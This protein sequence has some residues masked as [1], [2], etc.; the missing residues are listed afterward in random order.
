MRPKL[1]EDLKVALAQPQGMVVVSTPPGG[2]L[3]TLFAATISEMDRFV[4][5]FVGIESAAV[6]ELNVENVPMTY[7]DPAA[8][9]TPTAVLP[10][11]IREHPD[12]YVVPDMVDA[13]SATMLCE[14]VEQE[15]R[16]VVTSI[17]AK[18]AAESLLRV[19]MLKVPPAKFA[20]S[21]T[22]ALNQRLIRKL[23]PKCKE[24]YAPTAQVLEQLGIPAGRVEAFY[25]PPQQ[26]EEVCTDC[27][28]I[29]YLGRDWH[30]RAADRRRQ[31]ARSTYHESAIGGRPA[32]GAAGRA[33]ARCRKRGSCSWPRGSRRCKN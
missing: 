22:V 3:S 27:Q 15:N 33:C 18:E 1:I 21:V 5:G 32:S 8:G 29:G 24:G 10:K 23:C 9:Q 26:P 7:F 14:Q 20:A 16:M 30:L 13:E 17:R 12:V 4:R 6:K 25:R 19:M 11:L 31:R 28:G 2:G